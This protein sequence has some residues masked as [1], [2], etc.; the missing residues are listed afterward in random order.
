MPNYRKISRKNVYYYAHLQRLRDAEVLFENRRWIGCIYLAGIAAECI[1]KYA[2]CVR[3][4]VIHLEDAWPDLLSARGH[5][6]DLLL[7]RSGL[8]FSHTDRDIAQCFRRIQS[9]ST[10][11][12]YTSSDGQQ[13]DAEQFL[14]AAKAIC[15]WVISK[16][17]R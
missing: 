7:E 15:K 16:T 2:V 4:D 14:N 17:Y 9:W 1:L 3:E 8:I 13:I 5:E 11:I 10:H 6:L 12:R